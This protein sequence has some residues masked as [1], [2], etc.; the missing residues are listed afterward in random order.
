[1]LKFSSSTQ[2]KNATK[3]CYEPKVQQKLQ[4]SKIFQLQRRINPSAVVSVVS[5]RNAEKMLRAVGKNND[6]YAA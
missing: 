5:F 4:R 2:G 6:V 3:L 1:L